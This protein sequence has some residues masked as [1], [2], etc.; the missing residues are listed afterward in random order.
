MVAGG[1]GVLASGTIVALGVTAHVMTSALAI[2]AALP[3]VVFGTAAYAVARRYS[4]AAERVKLALELVLDR[5]EFADARS[6]SFIGVGAPQR[7]LLR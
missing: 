5:L 6:S 2:G 4:T 1:G 3:L 7:P